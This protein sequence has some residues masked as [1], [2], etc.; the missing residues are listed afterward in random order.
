[1]NLPIPGTSHK[2][3]HKIFV[4]L[5][6]TYFIQHVFVVQLW[7]TCIRILFLCMIE[8][9]SIVCK[10]HIL[11]IHS[12]IDGQLVV[13]IC[14][15]L[16][17]VLPWT[18]IYKYLF[19]SLLSTFGACCIPRNG[20]GWSYGNSMFNFLRSCQTVFHSGYTILCSHLQCTRVPIPP[21]LHLCQHPFLGHLLIIAILVDM[22]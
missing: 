22:K 2:L 12:S 9:Y 3:S 15:V 6:L 4:L 16:W 5:H 21:P 14:W 10:C 17:M 18:L 11:F 1:M 8:W 19:K 13:F 20:I 7:V